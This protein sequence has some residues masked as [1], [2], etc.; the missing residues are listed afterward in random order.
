MSG[1]AFST[2]QRKVVPDLGEPTMNS[3]NDSIC[4]PED[5]HG[6]KHTQPGWHEP[7]AVLTF[8]ADSRIDRRSTGMGIARGY[9]K[10]VFTARQRHSP[11]PLFVRLKRR[12]NGKCSSDE[13]A[14]ATRLFQASNAS[15]YRPV[16]L[17]ERGASG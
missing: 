8:L 10:Q 2:E 3:G 16:V 11:T 7:D 17:H 6:P 5:R 14:S 13:G 9:F 12:A 15:V 1:C 4:P